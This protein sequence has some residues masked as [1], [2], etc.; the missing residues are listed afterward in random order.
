MH[1]LKSVYVYTFGMVAKV[2]VCMCEQRWIDHLIH[3]L[4]RALP[5]HQ[6]LSLPPSLTYDSV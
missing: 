6:S 4:D 2:C 1:T 3:L 5:D